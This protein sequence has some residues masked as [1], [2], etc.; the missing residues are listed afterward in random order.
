MILYYVFNVPSRRTLQRARNNWVGAHDNGVLIAHSEMIYF[1][2]DVTRRNRRR[3]GGYPRRHFGRLVDNN[4]I[5]IIYSDVRVYY[6]SCL[7]AL[8]SAVGGR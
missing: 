3:D 1:R 6:T 4:N 8:R 7:C 2:P 5:I